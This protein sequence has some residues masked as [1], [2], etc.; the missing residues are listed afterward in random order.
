[1]RSITL[2]ACRAF[3]AAQP[4]KRSNTEVVVLPNVTV[5]KLFGNEIAYR[6]N[7]PEKTLS[8]TNCGWDSNTTKER[9]NGIEG[10]RIN[11]TKGQWYLSGK[12]WNGELINVK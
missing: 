6:Y 4:F 3:M 2:D 5:L 9:L 1:M 12:E 8:I 11:Q 10:V 7:D